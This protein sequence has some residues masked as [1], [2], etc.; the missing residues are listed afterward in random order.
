MWQESAL[1]G[2]VKPLNVYT[3]VNQAEIL[4][5]GVSAGMLGSLSDASYGVDWGEK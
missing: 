3:T 2:I 4:T 5:K 1:E